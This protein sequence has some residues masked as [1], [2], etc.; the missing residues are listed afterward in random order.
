MKSTT[1]LLV[2]YI[3]QVHSSFGSYFKK[4][5]NEFIRQLLARN[6]FH[7]TH[8]WWS[9]V[10]KPTRRQWLGDA[11]RGGGAVFTKLFREPAKPNNPGE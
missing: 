11:N 4:N 1:Y 5:K 3:F 9:K 8:D 6:L 10:S 2:V 7:I